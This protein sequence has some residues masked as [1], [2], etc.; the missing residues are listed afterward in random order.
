[1]GSPYIV[2]PSLFF[3]LAATGEMLTGNAALGGRLIAALAAALAVLTTYAFGRRTFGAAAGLIAGLVLATSVQ[4]W[5]MARWYRMD[6][7]FAAAMWG[8]VAWFAL[9]EPRPAAA[10]RTPR[11]KAWCGFYLFCGLAVLFKGPAGLGLPVLI[12]GG[13]FLLSRQSRR[14]AE[15]FDVRGITVFALVVAP[16]YVAVSIQEPSYAY[17]FLFMQ[18]VMRFG[19][20]TFGHTWPGILFVPILLLGLIPWTIYLAPAVRRH[21][22]R[23][24][25]GGTGQAAPLPLS[26]GANGPRG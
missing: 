12:I 15:F 26:L 10:A 23:R 6:M 11:W 7:P 2:E 19:S 25:R 13:Y 21:A 20:G 16:W 14:I 1:R 4:F 9:C 5:Y 18:N 8:A 17:E 22:P 24:W 3:C